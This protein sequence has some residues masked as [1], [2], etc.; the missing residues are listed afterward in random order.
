MCLIVVILRI[1]PKV[2][3][4]QLE[5]IKLDD[6]FEL[7]IVREIQGIFKNVVGKFSTRPFHYLNSGTSLLHQQNALLMQLL[8]Y[9]LLYVKHLRMKNFWSSLNRFKISIHFS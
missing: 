3:T 8:P 5:T 1:V 4:K 7:N 9:L 6:E 2:Q